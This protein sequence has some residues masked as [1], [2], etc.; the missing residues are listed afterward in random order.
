MA[1]DTRYKSGV[2][3][4]V[5]E[6]ARVGFLICEDCGASLLL[7]PTNEFDVVAI[8]DTWHDQIEGERT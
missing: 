8:H 7:D 2:R 5:A 1:K 6:G 4:V 3:A